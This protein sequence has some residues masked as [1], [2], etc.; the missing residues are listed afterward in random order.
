MSASRP[1]CPPSGDS[2]L[3]ILKDLTRGR[4]V[5]CEGKARLFFSQ[6]G[7]GFPDTPVSL[8]LS[9]LKD[10]SCSRGSQREVKGTSP[11][12]GILGSTGCSLDSRPPS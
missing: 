2:P 7:G 4:E 9:F 11:S 1:G 5:T 3:G 8:P 6:D 12:Q 10:H